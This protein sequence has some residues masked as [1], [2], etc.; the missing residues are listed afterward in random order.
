MT[1][2]PAVGIY[3]HPWDG[4]Q[5]WTPRQVLGETMLDMMCMSYADT[6]LAKEVILGTFMDSPAANIPAVVR[7]VA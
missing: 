6:G 7:M 4:M 3:K 5:P 2:R 1:V